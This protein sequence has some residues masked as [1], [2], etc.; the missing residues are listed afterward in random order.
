M[1]KEIR[2]KIEKSLTVYL[3]EL[4]SLFSLKKTS[5]LLFAHIQE[6]T[7]REGK[8]VRPALFVA[9]YLGFA[10]KEAPGLYTSALSLE[11]LHDFMLVHDDIIDKSELRRGRPSMHT[12][13][14]R[15]LARFY[16]ARFNGQDMA[17]VIGDVM[18][19][20]ALHS[21][22]AIRVD[23]ERKEKALKKLIE[24][25]LYT[26]T[27]ECIE[28]LT[29]IKPIEKTTLAEIYRIYDLKTACYTF[30]SPLC[31]GAILAGASDREARKLYRYGMTLGRAFQIKDDY[32][33]MFSDEKETGKSALSDIREAKKTVLIWYAYLHTDA[34]NRTRMKTILGKDR[35]GFEDLKAIRAIV[36]ASGS[37]AHAKKE[38][39]ILRARA[40]RILAS[41]R[42]SPRYKEA[43]NAYAAQIVGV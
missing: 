10:K 12:M 22:L 25:A 43:L 4:D 30:A 15:Y 36:T 1:L 13:L 19:A 35:A 14:N 33:G 31:M 23:K 27:G 2:N 17:I 39:H 6:F 41:S 37:L 21:F 32:L 20:L 11:L 26:G 9:A 24:A 34:K 40:E 7:A 5:P 8:R 29:G 18:Y 16:A 3:K 38:I 42:I 28:L